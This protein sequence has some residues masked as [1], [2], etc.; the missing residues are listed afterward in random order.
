M[1]YND[2]ENF[3]INPTNI[4]AKEFSDKIPEKG[5]KVILLDGG[6]I[7]KKYVDKLENIDKRNEL[8][9]S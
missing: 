4:A 6:D 3:L 5:D 2:F 1:N 7:L 8:L 9:R